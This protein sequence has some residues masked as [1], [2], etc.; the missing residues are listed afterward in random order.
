MGEGERGKVAL[1]RTGRMFSGKTR[2]NIPA[3]TLRL[4]AQEQQAPCRTRRSGIRA[5][6]AAAPGSPVPPSSPANLRI[7]LDFLFYLCISY[8][9]G[10]HQGEPRV[11]SV[12]AVPPTPPRNPTAFTHFEVGVTHPSLLGKSLPRAWRGMAHS[13]GWGVARFFDRGRIARPSPRSCSPL[14]LLS[15]PHAAFRATFPASRRR[16]ARRPPAGSMACVNAVA[17]NRRR[18]IAR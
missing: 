15:T 4:R 14:Y 2:S 1:A 8:V 7:L 3:A 18:R 5:R 16:G 11:S 10:L 9:H 6:V 13:A 12:E 17:R